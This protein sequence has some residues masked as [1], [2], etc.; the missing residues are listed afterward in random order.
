ME[1][2]AASTFARIDPQETYVL[3]LQTMVFARAEPDKD[4]S[5]IRRNVRRLQKHQIDGGRLYRGLELSATTGTRR[6]LQQPIRPAG[7]ARGRARRRGDQRRD[8]AAG[9]CLL[10]AVPERRRVVGLHAQEPSPAARYGSARHRQHD[11]P[12]I[13]SLV[14]AADR[15]RPRD[16]KVEGD[17]IICCLPHDPDDSRQDRTGIGMAGKPFLRD[18]QSRATPCGGCTT[19]TVW[20]GPGG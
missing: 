1:Q 20:S 19:F 17:H 4:A 5:L 3:S 12:G 2:G 14:I 18:A 7:A 16:A 6:Q 8:L 13:T 15:V 10:A 11:L 9:L